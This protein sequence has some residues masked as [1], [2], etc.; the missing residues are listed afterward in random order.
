MQ[1]FLW[2]SMLLLFS[3]G[4]SAVGLA[5]MIGFPIAPDI[6][7]GVAALAVAIV[8]SGIALIFTPSAPTLT[9]IK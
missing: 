9:P 2:S 1:V 7:V 3:I 8:V 4:G 6:S 5:S